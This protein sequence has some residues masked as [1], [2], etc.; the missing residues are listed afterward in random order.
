MNALDL[1]GGK[2]AVVQKMGGLLFDKLRPATL[3]DIETWQSI[4]GITIDL[5][6]FQ[7]MIG[8][9]VDFRTFYLLSGALGYKVEDV[10]TEP[11]LSDEKT[12]A[13]W[14][15][16]SEYIPLQVPGL[17]DHEV[18]LELYVFLR[19]VEELREPD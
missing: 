17:P 3:R 10:L 13:E 15:K 16:I 7:P 1:Y 9:G 2:R 18:P 6:K 11:D 19:A 4:M 12:R 14:Q 5:V 8:N